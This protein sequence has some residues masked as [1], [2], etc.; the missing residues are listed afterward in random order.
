MDEAGIN[1]V[2]L[3]GRVAS[4]PIERV[5]PDGTAVLEL[6]VQPPNSNGRRL[7]PLP[8]SVRRDSLGVSASRFK[9]IVK[10]VDKGAFIGVT[11]ELVRRFYRSG[12]GARSLTEVVA[13]DVQVLGGGGEEEEE[14]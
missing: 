2:V 5:L 12:A 4:D 10:Q 14:S 7:L 1:V 3:F 8:V 9:E 13:R 6:R 11:G